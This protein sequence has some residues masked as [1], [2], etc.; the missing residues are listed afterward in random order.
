MFIY[1]YDSS[2]FFY[3]VVYFKLHAKKCTSQIFAFTGILNE[4]EKRVDPQGGLQ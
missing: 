3:T 1:N 4:G 2:C